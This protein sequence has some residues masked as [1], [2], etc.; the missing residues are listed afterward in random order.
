M[1][2]L[3]L[4]IGFTGTFGLMLVVIG[5]AVLNGQSSNRDEMERVREEFE[6]IVDR[7]GTEEG[8]SP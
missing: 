1:I 4:L 8:G 5:A 2:L 3:A 6:R 7:L